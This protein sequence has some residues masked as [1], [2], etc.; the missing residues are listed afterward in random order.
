M[1]GVEAGKRIDRL[2]SKQVLKLLLAADT[3]DF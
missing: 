2:P 1:C 3:W